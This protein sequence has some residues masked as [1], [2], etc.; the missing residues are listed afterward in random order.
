MYVV[1]GIPRNSISDILV[2]EIESVE[3][4]KDAA[5]T[6]IYGSRG[7]NGVIIFTTKR[8]KINQP[9]Q[10]S[11]SSY[12]GINQ[13]KVPKL[14]SGPDYVQFRRDIYRSI[15]GWANGYG[16]DDKI[17]YLGELNTIKNG[18]Y[19]DWQDLLYRSGKNNEQGI[20]LSQG[21]EKAQVLFTL[22]YRNEEG[23]YRSSS[24]KRYNLG[25]N[26]D[27]SVSKMIKVGLSSRLTSVQTK[28]YNQSGSQGLA[29]RNPLAQPYDSAGKLINFPAEIQKGVFN[30]L[31]NYVNPYKNTNLGVRNFNVLYGELAFTKNLKLR[32]NL[33]IDY[34]QDN[35]DQFKG[36]YSFDQAGRASIKMQVFAFPK[37]FQAIIVGTDRRLYS[38]KA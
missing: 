29:Y 20:T 16:P 30:V 4:L 25:A 31:A 33:G 7:A 34:R 5:S 27:F 22:G 36:Q 10:I 26:I 8:A 14:I 32:S 23:Y 2:T 11:M 9:I 3:V 13:P 12:Y 17:F 37:T 18:N 35:G 15:Q 6:A 21:S 28:G 19:V 24:N 1:D 38:C